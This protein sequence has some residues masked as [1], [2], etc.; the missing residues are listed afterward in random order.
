[1]EV[2]VTLSIHGQ[3]IVKLYQGIGVGTVDQHATEIDIAAFT[4][5]EQFLLA[6]GGVLPR[7][8]ADPCREIAPSTKRRTRCR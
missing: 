3:R 7:H 1:M 4:Y 8:D 2:A 5:A 6:S